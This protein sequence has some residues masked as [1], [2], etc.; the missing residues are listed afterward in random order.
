MMGKFI[1]T[2]I[3]AHSFCTGDTVGDLS[4]ILWN[5]NEYLIKL[6]SIVAL[7]TLLH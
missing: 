2:E 7:I 5:N 1:I 6:M 4:K 3:R